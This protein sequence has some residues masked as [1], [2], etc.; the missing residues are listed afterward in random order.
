MVA[1]FIEDEVENWPTTSDLTAKDSGN[2]S[3][4]SEEQLEPRVDDIFKVSST[5]CPLAVS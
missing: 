4:I 5:R 1:S 3:I 2:E